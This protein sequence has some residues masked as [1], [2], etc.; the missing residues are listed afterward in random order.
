MTEE[1]AWTIIILQGLLFAALLVI[2]VLYFQTKNLEK[3]LE[4]MQYYKDAVSSKSLQDVMCNGS[5]V[6]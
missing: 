4:Y 5:P 2:S 3:E 6:K 1:N